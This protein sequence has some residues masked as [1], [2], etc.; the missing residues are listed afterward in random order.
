MSISAE[1]ARRNTSYS[2]FLFFFSSRA[3]ETWVHIETAKCVDHVGRKSPGGRIYCFVK[4]PNK[5]ARERAR[6]SWRA[7]AHECVRRARTM[8]QLRMYR[9]LL[10][11]EYNLLSLPSPAFP[12]AAPSS[13]KFVFLSRFL[14]VRKLPHRDSKKTSVASLGCAKRCRKSRITEAFYVKSVG[15]FI[16]GQRTQHD[17]FTPSSVGLGNG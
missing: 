9:R 11:P 13:P 6:G 7:M 16:P 1:N 4:F 14:A 12:L 5:P 15:H 3:N 10:S 8:V 2:P 17:D